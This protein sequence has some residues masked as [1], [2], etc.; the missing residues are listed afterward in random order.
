MDIDFGGII[1]WLVTRAVLPGLFTLAVAIFFWGVL[2]YVV[3]GKYDEE[4]RE[5]GKALMTYGL[6]VFAI[7]FIAWGAWAIATA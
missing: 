1:E 5:K 2:M 7:M 4:V 3:Q 6:G